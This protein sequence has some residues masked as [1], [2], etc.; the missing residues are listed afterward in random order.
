M[1]TPGQTRIPMRTCLGCREQ[2]PQTKLIR[3]VLLDGKVV[4]DQTKTA[5]GRGAYLHQNPECIS[6]ATSKRLFNRAFK[7]SGNLKVTLTIEELMQ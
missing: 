5:T 7:V 3:V 4:F 2:E 1:E 6:S